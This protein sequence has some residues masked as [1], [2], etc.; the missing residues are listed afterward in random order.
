MSFVGYW[1]QYFI[2]CASEEPIE[3]YSSQE[4]MEPR[5]NSTSTEQ[6]VVN[7]QLNLLILAQMDPGFNESYFCRK[8]RACVQSIIDGNQLEIFFKREN[9]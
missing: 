7:C 5:Y 3:K 9:V 1:I 6:C 4:L 8:Q 2:T